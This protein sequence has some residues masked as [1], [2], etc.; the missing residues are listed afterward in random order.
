MLFGKLPAINDPR[1]LKLASYLGVELPEIPE[2][3]KKFDMIKDWGMLGNDKYGCCVFAGAAHE[4]MFWNKFRDV[5]VPF[6]EK[7]VL[8]DYGAVTGFDPDV[9]SSDRGTYTIDALKYRQKTGMKD[10]VGMRHQIGAYAQIQV[11]EPEDLM[12]SVYLM[13]A[14]AIGFLCPSYIMTQ[15]SEGKPW[16]VKPGNWRIEGGHYVPIV[17]YDKDYV[18]CVTWGQI[19]PMTWEFYQKYTD[20]AYAII[21]EEMMKEGKSPEGFDI[22]S[23]EA[24]LKE[25]QEDK[26]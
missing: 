7:D 24:D 4:H 3:Y 11:D 12:A 5:D 26:K 14:T 2:S 20:E 10:A 22:A 13:K 23:L 16:S 1:T 21:S 6:K 25:I 19:Q 8:A 18:Y 17:G 15:L 9:P